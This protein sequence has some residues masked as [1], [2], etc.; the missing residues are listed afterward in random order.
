MGAGAGAGAGD[1]PVA[2]GLGKLGE[3]GAGKAVIGDSKE[4]R[5]LA[6][7]AR[8]GTLLS[9]GDD[10][11]DEAMAKLWGGPP[12][13][14]FEE[15][16]KTYKPASEAPVA[17]VTGGGGGI[18]FYISKGLAQLGFHVIIPARPGPAGAESEGAMKAIMKQVPGAKVTV[19]TATLDLNSLTSVRSFCAAIVSDSAVPKIDVLALNAGR[20]GGK[21]DP[22]ELTADG[23][24]A[25]MQVNAISHFLMVGELMPLLRASSSGRILFQSSIARFMASGH[26]HKAYD[27]DGTDPAV[28]NG[29]HQYAL[30]KAAQACNVKSLNERLM[31]YGVHNVVGVVVDP[32]LAATGVNIQHD[33]TN[34]I[35]LPGECH[36]EALGSWNCAIALSTALLRR[37]PRT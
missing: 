16:M 12:P 35:S 8:E 6:E 18:G 30:S 36:G 7:K 10:G 4:M 5:D 23:H 32:G 1:D 25:I 33:L 2:A 22:R 28:F 24:E 13:K 9:P 20:G 14:Y 27:P 15:A 31:A 17:L 29:F 34:S 3:A 37:S 26:K 21:D 19:P 11:Y